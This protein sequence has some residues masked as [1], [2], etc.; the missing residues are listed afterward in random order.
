MA[1][2][3]AE[4]FGGMGGR[5]EAVLAESFKG[6]PKE[7]QGKVGAEGVLVLPW[8][9]RQSYSSLAR[10]AVSVAEEVWFQPVLSW[11]WPQQVDHVSLQ[12]PCR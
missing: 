10:V 8:M 4:I 12:D 7:T 11:S 3:A 9:E 6:N 1:G 5:T 2:R